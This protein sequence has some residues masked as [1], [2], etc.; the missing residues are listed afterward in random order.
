MSSKQFEH[1]MNPAS[2]SSTLHNTGYTR[3]FHKSDMVDSSYFG[4]EKSMDAEHIL[5]VSVT[6]PPGINDIEKWLHGLSIEAGYPF[7]NAAM[8]FLSLPK[9]KA[10]VMECDDVEVQSGGTKKIDVIRNAVI[11]SRCNSTGY[12]PDSPMIFSRARINR[13]VHLITINLHSFYEMD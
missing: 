10:V 6:V 13:T 4:N 8:L 11:L 5:P 9:R 7:L 1:H 2:H 3:S 12:F